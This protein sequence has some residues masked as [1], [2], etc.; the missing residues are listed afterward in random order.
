MSWN[1]HAARR[2]GTLGLSVWHCPKCGRN[3]T[4]LRRAPGRYAKPVWGN[5]ACDRALIKGAADQ[6]SATEQAILTFQPVGHVAE[7]VDPSR[8]V[9]VEPTVAVIVFIPEAGAL[10]DEVNGRWQKSADDVWFV[11]DAKPF[12][13]LTAWVKRW[14]ATPQKL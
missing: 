14:A 12:K 9:W 7:S 10:S 13:Y 8:A 6:A 2:L 4:V 5:Q 11:Q 3:W 1:S